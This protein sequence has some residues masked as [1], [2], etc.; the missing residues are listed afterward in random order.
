LRCRE[1]LTKWLGRGLTYWWFDANWG[2]SIPPPM[3]PY[4][5]GGDGADYCGMSNRVWGS[6]VYYTTVAT[7]SAQNPN[8]SHTLPLDRPIALTK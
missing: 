6:H 7:F 2:F 8:R 4:S 3:V 5:G 1:G